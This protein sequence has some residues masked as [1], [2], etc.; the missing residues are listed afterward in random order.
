[1][2]DHLDKELMKI[3]ANREITWGI[4]THEPR[5]IE[6]SILVPLS[7]TSNLYSSLSSILFE[8]IPH[9]YIHPSY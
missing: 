7:R 4:A 9:P 6:Y 5:I 2:V 1:M 3:A 8:Y